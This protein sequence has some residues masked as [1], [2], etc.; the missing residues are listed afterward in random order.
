MSTVHVLANPAAGRGH[1]PDTVTTVTGMLRALGADP[2]PI[3]PPDR[4]TVTSLVQQAVDDGAT[5]RID[6]HGPRTDRP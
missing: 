3:D 4:S 6:Q 2:V 1:G 5:R